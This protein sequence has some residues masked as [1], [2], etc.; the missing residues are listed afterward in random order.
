MFLVS[1]IFLA[2]ATLESKDAQSAPIT[3]PVGTVAAEST[4]SQAAGEKLFHELGCISCHRPDGKGIGPSLA[5]VFGRPVTDPSCGVLTV[6][7]EYLREAILNP[8]TTV[9]E[10]FPPVMPSFAGTVTEEE[11]QALTAY[12]KSLSLHV[13]SQR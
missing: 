4:G 6:D 8:S 7:E 13:Q 11:L 9:A 3:S 2:A 5:G 10:G 12:V 1:A